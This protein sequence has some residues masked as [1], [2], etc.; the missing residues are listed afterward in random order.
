MKT[1]EQ[2][3][4]ALLYVASSPDLDGVSGKC[5]AGTKETSP[6]SA[7]YDVAAAERLW[8]ISEQLTQSVLGAA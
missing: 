3:A 4:D 2:A 8:Q 1:P 7:A 5:F 6:A